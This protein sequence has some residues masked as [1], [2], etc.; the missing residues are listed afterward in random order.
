MT[1]T[2]QWDIVIAGAGPTGLTLANFLG[3]LGVRTLVLE[4]L[5]RLIDYPRGVGMDDETLR[6]FQA[7]GLA[8]QVRSHTVPGQVMR[9]LDAKRRLIAAINPQAQPFGWPRR[10]GF[11]QPLV[12]AEL[13]A[14]L[15]RF[16]NVQLEFQHAVAGFAE[17]GDGIAITVNAVDADG[18]A[19][20]D[21][22]VVRARY[23][24]GC[25]GGRSPVRTALGVGF[26]GKSESTRWL[27]IDVGDD[28]VGTPNVSLVLDKEFPYVEIALPHGVRRFEFMVPAGTDDA[29]FDD[30]A[31]VRALLGRV[32]PQPGQVRLI[33]HRVYTHHARIAPTF[34]QGRVFLAG[35]AAHL[36]PV[37][38]GQGFNTGIRD[39]T[40]LAWKLA[41]VV[42]GR[43]G[44]AL[45]D[46]YTR[47]RH[48]HAAAM[49]DLSVLVG[50]IFVPAHAAL[51]LLRDL[52]APWLSRIPSLRQF[53]AEMRF[54]PMPFFREGAVV[55][56]P[57]HPAP[58]PVGRMFIQPRVRTRDGGVALLDDVLG[59][60]FAIVSWSA[61]ADAW[62][63][64]AART[65]LRALGAV[66]VVVRP[67]CQ[68][69]GRELP[70][71]GFAVSDAEGS[72]RAWFDAAPGSVIVLRPD[73]AIA[74]VCNP[75]TLSA[76]LERLAQVLSLQPVP[77]AAQAEAAA[78]GIQQELAA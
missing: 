66:S 11:I 37:W 62:I 21:A 38:Q 29:A 54:K 69:L 17:D 49:I 61:R 57:S 43:A 42:Q 77:P 26:P 16:P 48:P 75:Q 20:G 30:R 12:D 28:P 51:R 76:T 14:G 73:R 78:P 13:F 56:D 64:P 67:E 25:D 39:A 58:S 33:R 24:V 7:L 3:M 50:R 19:T 60:R 9:F 46:S 44:D 68:D 8:A 31:R 40:N 4:Q 70:Q 59:P 55:H 65:V 41:L 34:R 32:L 47:E 6:T 72:L 52:V 2:P 35:D 71:D 15:R 36:M 53:I 5:P 10:S 45:L 74:A 27:V 23:L 18:Q 1:A 22:H 63:T